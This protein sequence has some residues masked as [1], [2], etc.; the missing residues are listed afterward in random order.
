MFKRSRL[1]ALCNTREPFALKVFT[2]SQY[3]FL[4]NV[5]SSC[6]SVDVCNKYVL[7]L[8]EKLAQ[9]SGDVIYD[10]AYFHYTA[11]V[12]SMFLD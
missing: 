11:D 3:V 10:A 6:S 7:S 8:F 5:S 1:I 9:F 4:W 2:S 12:A